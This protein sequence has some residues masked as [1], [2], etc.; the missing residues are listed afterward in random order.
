MRS[1]VELNLRDLRTVLGIS[2]ERVTCSGVKILGRCLEFGKEL[3]VDAFLNEDTRTGG[4]SLAWRRGAKSVP[5]GVKDCT[6]LPTH[7][8][9]SDGTSN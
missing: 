2:G 8:M 3:V 5:T 1:Y 7:V 4:A 6:A 9:A